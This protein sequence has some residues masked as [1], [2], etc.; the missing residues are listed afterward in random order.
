LPRRIASSTNLFCTRSATGCPGQAC[1]RNSTGPVKSRNNRS[2]W[3]APQRRTVSIR[4]AAS[5][6][7]NRRDRSDLSVASRSRPSLRNQVS[8]AQ[9]FA[10]PMQRPLARRLRWSRRGRARARLRFRASRHDP[11]RRR[12]CAECRAHGSAPWRRARP[13]LRRARSGSRPTRAP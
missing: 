6:L 2:S 11:S 1:P 4:A 12:A 13:R 5:A 10:Q 9:Q 3:A 8:G 7:P